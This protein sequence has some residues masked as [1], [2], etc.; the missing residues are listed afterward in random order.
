MYELSDERL[1]RSAARGDASAFEVVYD[2]HS[3]AAYARALQVCGDRTLAEDV[4]QD[5]FLTV[6]RNAA[7]FDRS[8]GSA[9]TWI[10][11]IVQHRAIDA[12]RRQRR[13]RRHRASADGLEDRLEATGGTDHE[14]MRRELGEVVRT[15]LRDLPTAQRDVI[16]LGHFRGL[17]HAEIAD[18]LGDPLGTVKGRMR[19]GLTKMRRTLERRAYAES[20][21]TR[22]PAA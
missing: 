9:R 5:A 17:S 14:V 22:C 18:A 8:R 3:R 7:S 19:L 16:V 11:A 12:L 2:R 6:W 21:Q 1:L 20:P 15:A 10:L 13:H 4:L